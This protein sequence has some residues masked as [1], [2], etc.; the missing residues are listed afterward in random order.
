VRSTLIGAG[1]LG[2][3]VTFAPLL[4]PSVR[5]VDAEPSEAVALEAPDLATHQPAPAG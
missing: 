5:R 2:A 1:V 4:I 3:V